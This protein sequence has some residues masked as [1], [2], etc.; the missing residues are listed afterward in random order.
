MWGFFLFSIYCHCFASSLSLVFDEGGF[1]AFLF[2]KNLFILYLDYFL[3]H[4]QFVVLFHFWD[5]SANKFCGIK[6]LYVFRIAF[7][8]GFL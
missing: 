7:V 4:N 1:G 5:G 3:D 8:A 6:C 2:G